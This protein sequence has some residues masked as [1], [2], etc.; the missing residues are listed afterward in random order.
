MVSQGWDVIH[1]PNRDDARTDVN[2]SL[3]G[4][5]DSFTDMNVN[6][7]PVK[8]KIDGT[9]VASYINGNNNKIV[10]ANK[11]LEEK[12]STSFDE[13]DAWIRTEINTI[14]LDN[15]TKLSGISI[16]HTFHEKDDTTSTSNKN[17]DNVA[18]A[19]NYD[20]IDLYTPIVDAAGHVVGKNT[21]T[22]TLPYGFKTIATN[23]RSNDDKTENATGT[24]VTTNIVAENTQDALVINSGNKWVRIDTDANN[25][26]IIISHDVHN[27]NESAGTT[28]WTMTEEN[29]T[30]PTIA[31]EFDNA[32]HYI[33]HH[34]ENYKLP[35][36][37]GKVIGDVG[38]TEATAT[39]DEIKFTSDEWLTATVSK[40]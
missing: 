39:Y 32:G 29:T 4:R 33:S 34:T 14:N 37:Y 23:G 1:G 5:L 20:K 25:D 28:D 19:N 30:I 9:L 38:N 26:T 2:G 40:D 27:T 17:T 8:R 24:P 18:S 35:F 6:A 10:E 22:V 15:E 7:I 3:Q 12:L 11:I 16:H 36:G 13:D 31:Y 21:E